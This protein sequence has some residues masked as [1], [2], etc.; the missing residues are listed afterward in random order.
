MSTSNGHNGVHHPVDE[1]IDALYAW[2]PGTTPAPQPLPE[3]ALSLTLKGAVGGIEALLTIRGQT[4]AEFQRNLASVKGLLDQPQPPVQASSQAE[5]WCR[6][7][8]Q[9]MKENE[10][11]GRRWFSHQVDGQWCKGR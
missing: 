5:G 6:K 1:Q 3:A 11:N 9:Q 4:P 7:H 2:M 8:G 10:K